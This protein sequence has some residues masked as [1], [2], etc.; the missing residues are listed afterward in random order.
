LTPYAGTKACGFKELA[1]YTG[2][3]HGLAIEA[4]AGGTIPKLNRMREPLALLFSIAK[5]ILKKIKLA[6]FKVNVCGLRER[7]GV[8][9]FFRGDAHAAS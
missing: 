6:V 7:F 9:C 1:V 8:G 3:V 4:I 2:L 5:K